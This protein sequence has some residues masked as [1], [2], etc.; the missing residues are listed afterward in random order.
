MGL[1]QPCAKA[2]TEH[3]ITDESVLQV[4]LDLIQPWVK[5]ITRPGG[6]GARVHHA[7]G[8]SAANAVYDESTANTLKRMINTVRSTLAQATRNTHGEVACL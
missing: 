8:S 1:P 5:H 2:Y 6:R 3:R 4:L 7:P